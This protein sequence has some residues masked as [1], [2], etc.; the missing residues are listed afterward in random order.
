MAVDLVRREAS[1]LDGP[2]SCAA[3]LQNMDYAIARDKT[4]GETT[5]VVAVISDGEVYGASVGDSGAWLVGGKGF[6]DLT[7][8][9]IR[10]P[11]LGS[12]CAS[13][14]SFSHDVVNGGILLL[15]TDGLFKYTSSDRIENVCRLASPEAAPKQLI[16]LVRYQSGALPDD[17]TIIFAHL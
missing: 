5:C 4:A 13:P 12:G 15:A 6:E 8:R 1:V 11:F 10:K 14:I 17:I 2:D 16:E 9:Q 3:L 7:K